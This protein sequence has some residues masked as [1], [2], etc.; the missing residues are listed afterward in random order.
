MDIVIPCQA[1]KNEAQC[2]LQLNTANSIH[3][4]FKK[5][6]HTSMIYDKWQILWQQQIKYN[7]AFIQ[8]TSPST[9]SKVSYPRPTWIKRP[10]PVDGTG[11]GTGVGWGWSGNCSL[12]TLG[13]SSIAWEQPLTNFISCH[14]QMCLWWGEVPL[15]CILQRS[16]GLGKLIW[17]ITIL[18]T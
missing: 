16:P 18:R 6:I 14:S 1:P 13:W 5:W 3:S 2:G 15:E 9:A 4:I 11:T 8:S 10:L 7:I 12:V 17:G